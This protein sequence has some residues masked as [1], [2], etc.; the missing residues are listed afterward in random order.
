MKSILKFHDR[1]ILQIADRTYLSE[2]PHTA[3]LMTLILDVSKN[4]RLSSIK[5]AR[6]NSQAWSFYLDF[7][8]CCRMYSHE[9]FE[10]L[11]EKPLFYWIF[12]AFIENL[13]P[14]LMSELSIFQEN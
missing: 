4:K 9:K 5:G 10:K 13:S 7:E 3:E 14:K 1:L 11:I 2:I 6:Y 8:D 12:T